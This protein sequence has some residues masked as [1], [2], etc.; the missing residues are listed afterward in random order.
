MK[1]SELRKIVED[2]IQWANE[3]AEAWVGTTTG[4]IIDKQK[5]HVED[6]VKS[7]DLNLA[8]VAVTELAQTC[9]Y[10]EKELNES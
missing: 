4:R 9:V 10:A 8:E 3:L 6:L 7:N 5:E 1:E 2:T